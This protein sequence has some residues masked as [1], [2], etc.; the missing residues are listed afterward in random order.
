MHGEEPQSA[1][2]LVRRQVEAFPELRMRLSGLLG[3]SMHPEEEPSSRSDQNDHRRDSGLNIEAFCP[4]CWRF[5]GKIALHSLT[6]LS[7]PSD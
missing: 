5:A 7:L 3:P 2:Q 4:H 6:E 1:D